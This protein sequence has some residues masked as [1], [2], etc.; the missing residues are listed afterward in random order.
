LRQRW[1]NRLPFCPT[2]PPDISALASE[3][4]SGNPRAQLELGQAYSETKDPEKLSLS[5]YWFEKAAQQG[6]A[7][8]EWRLSWAYGAGEGVPPD[9][10][11]ALNWLKKAA[12]DGQVRAQSLLGMYYRDGRFVERD[13]K[14]AFD[15]F[16]RAAKQGDVDSL[17]V[18]QMYEEGDVVPQDYPQAVSWY[19]K[20]AEHVPDYGGAGVARYNLGMV[21]L[22]GNGVSQ[23]YMTAY[24]YFA[25]AN[26]KENMQWAAEKMTSSQIAEAQHRATDWVQQHPEPQICSGGIG[27]SKALSI[28]GM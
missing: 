9:D 7:D 16:L 1:L 6:N 10:K 28:P 2:N 17:S 23:D 14:K 5:I 12:E 8:A 15:L 4:A 13:E 19:K 27:F 20:A 21:Y 3:A 18:A 24:M 11:S 22:E 26:N 25:L